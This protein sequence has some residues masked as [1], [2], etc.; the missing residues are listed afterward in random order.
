MIDIHNDGPETI[1]SAYFFRF[2]LTER[3]QAYVYRFQAGRQ[4][5][6]CKLSC[7]NPVTGNGQFNRQLRYGLNNFP[8]IFSYQWYSPGQAYFFYTQVNKGFCDG[9]N[10]LLVHKFLPWPQPYSFCGHA[11]KA[12]Q[13]A[14]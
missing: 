4:K 13:V 3:I 9:N 11:V 12:A 2:L 5:T 6:V 10:F 8:G 1:P 14:A 7:Q